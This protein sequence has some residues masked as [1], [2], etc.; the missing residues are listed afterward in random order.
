MYVYYTIICTVIPA[1]FNSFAMA[2]LP[3][4]LSANISGY[5]VGGFQFPTG[6]WVLYI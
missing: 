4:L 3:N 6:Y 5:M 2:Q 1:T